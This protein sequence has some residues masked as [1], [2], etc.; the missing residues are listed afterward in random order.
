MATIRDVARA[1]DVSP[2]T[3]SRVLNGTAKVSDETNRRVAEAARALDYWPNGAARSLIRS[4]THTIG[5]LLPDMFGEFFSEVLRGI[6]QAV[7]NAG[8]QV[9]LS[10]SQSTAEGLLSAARAMTGRVEGFLIMA[11]DESA[12]ASVD[13]IR[14]RFP[15]VVLNPRPSSAA[16]ASVSIANYEGAVSAVSHLARLGHRRIATV[17][18]PVGNADSDARRRGYEVALSAHGLVLD[19]SMC[20]R[21][22]FTESSGYEAGGWL[23]RQSPIP[24]AIFAANDGMA[25]GLI[26]RLN[27]AGIR[28]PEDI[29]VMGFDDI[30]TARYLAPP[31]STVRVDA[32][33]LG[34]RAVACL[35]D[36]L[37]SEDKGREIR[38]TIPWDLVIRRSC[39]ALD[40]PKGAPP[41]LN[42]GRYERSRGASPKSSEV[43]ATR[44]QSCSSREES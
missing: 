22:A 5:V 44:V 20:V 38:C 27:E 9:L 1:A 24:T 21:G 23:L 32:H 35:L 10:S 8:L 18:G 16:T 17:S 43:K 12:E 15:V 14:K 40:V 33:G 2:A 31:L 26:S 11:P 34:A 37:A 3:V 36:L 29:A 13:R 28:V 7:R 4:H 19:P 42:H 41:L 30:P 25:I 6:D 39:G